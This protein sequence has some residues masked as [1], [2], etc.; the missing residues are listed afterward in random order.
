MEDQYRDEMVLE[1]VP[2]AKGQLDCRQ[3]RVVLLYRF[4]QVP[5]AVLA[6]LVFDIDIKLVNLL[7]LA[8]SLGVEEQLALKLPDLLIRKHWLL[9][10]F[11]VVVLELIHLEVVAINL[12]FLALILAVNLGVIV[13]VH[14]FYN[15]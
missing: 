1:E 14:H 15:L 13:F 9:L 2:A 11:L 5:D 7:D 10:F 12:P 8:N 3:A 4:N 6:V